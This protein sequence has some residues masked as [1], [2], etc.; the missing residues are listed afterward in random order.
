MYQKVEAEPISELNGLL[1][2]FSIFYF[3]I[4]KWHGGYPWMLVKEKPN[5]LYQQK[6]VASSVFY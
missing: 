3:G 6:G 5:Q 4:S 2:G 1:S